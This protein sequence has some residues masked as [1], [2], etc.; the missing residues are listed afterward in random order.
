MSK[1]F[2]EGFQTQDTLRS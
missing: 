2:L 1:F